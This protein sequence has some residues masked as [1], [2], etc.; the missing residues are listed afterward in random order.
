[1]SKTSL[2]Q[3]PVLANLGMIIMMSPIHWILVAF[4]SGSIPTSVWLG[5]LFLGRDIREYG[6]GNPGATNVFRAGS[7]VLGV[8]SL[9]LDVCKAA[10]PVGIC[11]FNLAYKG[12]PMLL[13][14]SAPLLGHIYSPF[15]RF[16]GGKALAATLGVWIGL[17]TWQVSLPA[18]TGVIAGILILTTSGWAVIFA[19]LV[20]LAALLIFF[21]EPLFLE[22]WG[23]QILLL[24]WTHREDLKKAPMVKD[25]VKKIFTRD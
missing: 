8:I 24:A 22:V 17:T 2:V 7:P 5:R 12:L 19:M 11:Y 10:I 13:I 9:L 20:I 14:A 4:L 15:L 25:W 1:M 23:V 18:V 16:K 3:L 6:D 21:Q